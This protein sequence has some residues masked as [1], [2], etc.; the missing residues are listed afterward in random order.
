MQYHPHGSYPV[1]IIFS[2]ISP[3]NRTATNGI[4]GEGVMISYSDAILFSESLKAIF[5][6]RSVLASFNVNVKKSVL[7]LL[8]L[9]YFILLCK[10]ESKPVLQDTSSQQV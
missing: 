5:F 9:F 8:L 4:P 10:G 2:Q 1:V 6:S 3:L 7:L